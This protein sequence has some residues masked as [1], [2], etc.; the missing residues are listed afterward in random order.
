[1]R[2]RSLWRSDFSLW[3]EEDGE[4][5]RWMECRERMPEEDEGGWERMLRNRPL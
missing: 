5:W 4:V 2:E 3:V 1:M